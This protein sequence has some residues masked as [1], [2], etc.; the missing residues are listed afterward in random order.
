M[1]ILCKLG[2]HDFERVSKPVPTKG[3][4]EFDFIVDSYALGKC[5]RCN[6]LRMIRCWSGLGPYFPP[7]VK[8]KS[9]WLQELSK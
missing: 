8:T 4:S 9:E 5:R 6:K 7:D 3:D 2:L 1:K